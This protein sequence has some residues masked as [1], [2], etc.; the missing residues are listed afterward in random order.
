LLTDRDEIKNIYRGYSLDA[1]YQNS[2]QLA[3]KSQEA[4]MEGSLISFL[5]A[6]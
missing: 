6:E 1:S 3:K 4:P 2:V 5:K